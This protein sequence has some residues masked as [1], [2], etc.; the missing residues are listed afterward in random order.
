MLSVAANTCK[1]KERKKGK[2]KEEKE[3]EKGEGAT[4]GNSTHCREVKYPPSKPTT[5]PKLPCWVVDEVE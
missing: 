5:V 4:K 2:R 3:K 1:E